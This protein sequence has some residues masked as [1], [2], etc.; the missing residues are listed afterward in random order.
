MQ[1]LVWTS[2]LCWHLD[3]FK[4]PPGGKQ[5]TIATRNR[6][7]RNSG[8]HS[9]LGTLP[10]L[11]LKP[12]GYY[13]C[14]Q[15]VFYYSTSGYHSYQWRWGSSLVTMTVA[16]PQ[17][18]VTNVLPISENDVLS[19]Y[20][21]HHHHYSWCQFPQV[22]FHN[23]QMTAPKKR[24]G[25]TAMSPGWSFFDWLQPCPTA[26]PEEQVRHCAPGGDGAVQLCKPWRCCSAVTWQQ[27]APRPLKN[28]KPC[29]N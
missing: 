8:Y 27:A 11:V 28:I 23:I 1:S 9:D 15:L 2:P 10:V 5:S 24:S 4:G 14:Y 20:H 7:S 13:N 3:V 21:G 6:C 22:C 19:G 25:P 26:M 16:L 12:S 18:K 17:V 29:V